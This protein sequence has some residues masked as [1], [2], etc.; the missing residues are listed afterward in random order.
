MNDLN[1]KNYEYFA[2][3][4]LDLYDLT[5]V[6]SKIY[7]FELENLEDG[8]ISE[9]VFF[10]Y[11]AI[12]LLLLDDFPY[13]TTEGEIRKMKVRIKKLEILLSYYLNPCRDCAHYANLD[14]ALRCELGEK[15][16]T[17]GYKNKMLYLLLNK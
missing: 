13:F 7:D 4:G 17:C 1:Q 15:P 10:T 11:K 16:E 5:E 6:Y 2:I 12:L 3:D 8:E 9:E 14:F